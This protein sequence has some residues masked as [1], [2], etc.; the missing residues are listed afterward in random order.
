MSTQ[1]RV[2]GDCGVQVHGT[3]LLH[4][5]L[6]LLTCVLPAVERD[7]G[8]RGH[9]TAELRHPSRPGFPAPSSTGA[10][11][12]GSATS[13]DVPEATAAE[14]CS[15]PEFRTGK[16][17]PHLGQGEPISLEAPEPRGGRGVHRTGSQ[18]WWWRKTKTHRCWF[19]QKL[20]W[21]SPST[22]R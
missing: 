2:P 11:Q 12:D 13:G 15:W 1:L 8:W 4:Y 16:R 3:D 6:L 20:C 14:V 18:V 19:M 7:A 9:L 17:K 21:R 10:L 5:P 22:L